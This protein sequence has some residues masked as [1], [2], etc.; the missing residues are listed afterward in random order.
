VDMQY[1]GVADPLGDC[2]Q[3]RHHHQPALMHE[4]YSGCC[5]V[6][7]LCRPSPWSCSASTPCVCVDSCRA[8]HPRD[9]QGMQLVR[10]HTL[11]CIQWVGHV[12]AS[13][14][15]VSYRPLLDVSWQPQSASL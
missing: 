13:L 9:L 12:H 6:S 5:S 14:L 10:M 7:Y 3:C 1:S 2:M 15:W 4:E 8:Y 11:Q